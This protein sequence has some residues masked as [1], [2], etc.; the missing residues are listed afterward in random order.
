MGSSK[1]CTTPL[2]LPATTVIGLPETPENAQQ[3]SPVSAMKNP[4]TAP[5]VLQHSFRDRQIGAPHLLALNT[6]AWNILN[7]L[8]MMLLSASTTKC[9][10]GKHTSSSKLHRHKANAD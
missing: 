7:E 10:L 1:K 8:A 9:T 6:M 4:S 2:S 3:V 5:A